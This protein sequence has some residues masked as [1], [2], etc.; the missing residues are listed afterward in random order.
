M[1]RVTSLCVSLFLT[2]ATS[3]AEAGDHHHRAGAVRGQ[4]VTIGG[5][6]VSGYRG[7]SGLSDFNGIPYYGYGYAYDPY[8]H[9]SFHAP[10]LLNEPYFRAQHKF[11]SQFPGRYSRRPR[12]QLRGAVPGH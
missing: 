1:S 3:S 6:Y 2:I 10:D 8:R 9:G 4:S 11:D 5:G 12:L 7:Y